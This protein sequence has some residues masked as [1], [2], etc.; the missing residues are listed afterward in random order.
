MVDTGSKG[1]DI[2]FQVRQLS[3]HF[4]AKISKM[5]H[6]YFLFSLQH[7]DHHSHFY[8]FLFFATIVHHAFPPS[9]PLSSKHYYNYHHH[10]ITSIFFATFLLLSSSSSFSLSTEKYCGTANRTQLEGVEENNY[11]KIFY[12]YLYLVSFSCLIPVLRNNPRLVTYHSCLL[13]FRWTPRLAAWYKVSSE[14]RL[15]QNPLGDCTAPFFM[16]CVGKKPLSRW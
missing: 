9:P 2:I 13:A 14:I 1:S 12:L 7:K 6:A 11:L 3:V 8:C 16:L 15:W 5:T 10:Q 4:C